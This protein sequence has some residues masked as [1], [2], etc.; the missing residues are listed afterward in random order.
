MGKHG[1]QPWQY[2]R[3]NVDVHPSQTRL[4]EVEPLYASPPD[5]ELVRMLTE[6]LTKCRTSICGYSLNG[7][8]LQAE[9]VVRRM[10]NELQRIDGIAR[11]ALSVKERE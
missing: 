2:S 7:D 3:A 11:A 10:N 8:Y 5:G 9:E 6:A 1:E 4:W